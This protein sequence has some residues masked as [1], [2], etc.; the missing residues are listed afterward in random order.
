[1]QRAV[2][3][4]KLVFCKLVILVTMATCFDYLPEASISLPLLALLTL[5]I[6]VEAS[7]LASG[8]VEPLFTPIPTG[9]PTKHSL[10]LYGEP[11]YVKHQKFTV[12]MKIQKSVKF[13]S[14]KAI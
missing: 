10:S 11:E 2:F 7:K 9:D 12:L 6:S 5:L 4:C 14:F 1:M 3:P 8:I 13:C